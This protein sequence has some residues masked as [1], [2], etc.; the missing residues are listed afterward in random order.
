MGE[1]AKLYVVDGEMAG[2]FVPL[3]MEEGRRF[4][5]GRRN[6]CDLVLRLDSISREH[7][8]IQKEADGH[9]V[10][11]NGSANATLVN[12]IAVEKARLVHGDVLTLDKITMEYV[13]PDAGEKAD[14]E[15]EFVVQHRPNAGASYNSQNSMI[16]QVVGEKYKLLSVLGEGGMAVVYKARREDDGSIVAVKVLKQSGSS[17]PE[18]HR[19]FIKEFKTGNKLQHDG[20]M[21][22]YDFGEHKGANFMV[23]EYIAGTSL[24]EILDEKGKLSQKATLQVGVQVTK[25]LEYALER[26]IIHRDIKPEN[27][28]ISKTGEV[29]L[30]DLGLAKEMKQFVSINLTKTGEGIGTLHYMSPEQVENTKG[31]DQRADIY[32]LGASLYECLCGEPPFDEVGVWK[33]IEAINEKDPPPLDQRVAGLHPKM[34]P[35]IKKSLEKKADKRQQTPTEFRREMEAI[36]AEL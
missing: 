19:R 23:M 11:D 3:P 28:M 10:Q 26:N 17:D 4:T 9:H 20:I 7:C 6:T 29:K 13:S 36:L 24:Q 16:G 34:W 15:R 30:A 1:P 31:V 32:S 12:G 14:V 25:A 33:F 8:V 35:M 22:V 18:S 2:N 5:I 21:Q 27:I